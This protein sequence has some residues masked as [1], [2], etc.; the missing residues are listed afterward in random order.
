MENE[1]TEKKVNKMPG[2]SDVT[3]TR[4]E[5]PKMPR[6]QKLFL[7][8]GAIVLAL[9]VSFIVYMANTPKFENVLTGK[10][11]TPLPQLS[12]SVAKNEAEVEFVT[13]AGNI[14]V[15]LFPKLAPKAVESFLTLSKDGYYKNNQFFRILASSKTNIGIIQSGSAKNS[16]SVSKYVFGAPF[17]NEISPSL[18]NIYGSLSLANSGTAASNGSQ[19]FFNTNKV[20]MSTSLT[21]DNWPAKIIKAYKTG[22]NP[23]FDGSYTVFGQ[24]ISGLNVMDTIAKGKTTTVTDASTGTSE[25]SKPVKPVTIKEVKVLKD[26]K[27]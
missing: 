18:Y 22:G 27:F 16:A 6:G 15:K 26:W 14:T 2:S 11:N 9:L 20:D 1:T 10:A 7:G 5:K 12:T 13:T 21:T 8:I 17:K 4:P 25:Q 24:V 23:S 3:K 19:F